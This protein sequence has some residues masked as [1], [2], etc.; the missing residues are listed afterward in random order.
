MSFYN[1]NKKDGNNGE[2]DNNRTL[3]DAVLSDIKIPESECTKVIEYT[4]TLTVV[5]T[6]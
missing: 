3:Y 4:S 1:H 6:V 2:N 5:G